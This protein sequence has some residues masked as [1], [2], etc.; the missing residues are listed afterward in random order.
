[1]TTSPSSLLQKWYF[2]INEAGFDG[3]F[4]LV[5]AAVASARA[6]TTLSPIC[7]YGGSNTG[8]IARLVAL[9]VTVICH[10]SSFDADLR[11]G[12]GDDYARFNGH[13]LRVDLPLIDP[14]D[15]VVLYTDFDV[16]FL[17]QPCVGARP[18]CLGAGPE[19]DR[20]NRTYFSSGVMVLNL[21][22][23]RAVHRAFTAQIRTRLRGRF[24]YPAHDQFSYNRFFQNTRMN[25][26]RGRAFVGVDPAHNWKP[27]WGENPATTILHF[28]GPKPW[29][30]RAFAAGTDTGNDAH[31]RAL[32]AMW[33]S[34][35]EAYAQA[36][37]QWDHYFSQG[38]AMISGRDR[39]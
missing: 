26:W 21:R 37:G 7:I 29:D 8:H 5:T 1:M 22:G 20:E 13:W 17:G 35:P 24:K 15:D 19:F 11:A 16:I 14:S 3:Y 2:C 23:L 12:Y 36:L 6:N 25:R 10:I 39:A 31:R 28:H 27:F 32:F 30:V 4:P 33:Q 18:K 34:A 38:R 9:G